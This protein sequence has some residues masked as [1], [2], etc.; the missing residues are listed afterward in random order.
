MTKQ[1]E[2]IFKQCILTQVLELILWSSDPS[3]SKKSAAKIA[4]QWFPVIPPTQDAH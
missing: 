3:F 4:E 2:L 1:M